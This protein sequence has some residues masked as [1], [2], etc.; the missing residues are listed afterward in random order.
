M[1]GT[2]ATPEHP[3]TGIGDELL[4]EDLQPGE[5][6]PLASGLEPGETVGDLLEDGKPADEDDDDDS[7]D[8]SDDGAQPA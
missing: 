7:D 3:S 1:S 2:D 6:N 8:D 5:D 4:P